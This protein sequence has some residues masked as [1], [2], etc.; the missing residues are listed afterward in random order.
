M[1]TYGAVRVCDLLIGSAVSGFAQSGVAGAA[2]AAGLLVQAGGAQELKVPAEAMLT[3]ASAGL[4]DSPGFSS[5][6][7]DSSPE[8]LGA[9]QN[10]Q[11]VHVDHAPAGS[12]AASHFDKVIEPGA[13]GGPSDGSGQGAAGDSG[14]CDA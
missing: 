3:T 1:S 9:G 14:E 12:E 8:G 6:N 10:G 13:D 2:L 7:P 11:T 4:P 5:S